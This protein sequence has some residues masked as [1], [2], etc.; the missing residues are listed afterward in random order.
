MFCKASFG[1]INAFC[2]K[3]VFY[4]KLLYRVRQKPVLAIANIFKMAS[5]ISV[6]FSRLNRKSYGGNLKI[7]LHVTYV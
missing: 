5:D 7:I 1:K 6:Q 3:L 4:L 2:E